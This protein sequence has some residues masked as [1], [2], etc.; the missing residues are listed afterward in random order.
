[1]L[2]LDVQEAVCEALPKCFSPVPGG[3]GRMGFT[4][5]DLSAVSEADLV[6]ALTEAHARATAPK[7]KPKRPRA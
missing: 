2:D 3:W 1:M 5:V 7:P 6:G 4:A